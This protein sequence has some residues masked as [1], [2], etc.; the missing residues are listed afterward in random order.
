MTFRELVE[1]N[2]FLRRQLNFC[3]KRLLPGDHIDLRDMWRFDLFYKSWLSE[4][5]ELE[6]SQIIFYNY[7]RISL[8]CLECYEGMIPKIKICKK[9][10]NYKV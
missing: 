10:I 8:E 3:F 7:Q 2:P 1:N 5:C 6:Y 4:G 9:C